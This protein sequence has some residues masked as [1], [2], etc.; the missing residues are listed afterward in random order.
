MFSCLDWSCRKS[1]ALTHGAT[2]VVLAAEPMSDGRE[3]LSYRRCLGAWIGNAQEAVKLK[4]SVAADRYG[5][6]R[7]TRMRG[8]KG[9]GTR[10]TNSRGETACRLLRKRHHGFSVRG[11]PHAQHAVLPTGDH[12]LAIR[13]HGG[14]LHEVGDIGEAP[15]VLSVGADGESG[16]DRRSASH[17]A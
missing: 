9:R 10:Q 4:S 17:G 16:T 7:R 15:H 5:E 8:G 1:G 12:R 3:W 2:L 13:A 11:I 6:A 14:G